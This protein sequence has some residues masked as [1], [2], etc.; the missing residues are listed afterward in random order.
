MPMATIEKQTV[1]KSLLIAYPNLANERE[2]VDA[3][4]RKLDEFTF[5]AAKQAVTEYVEMSGDK[6]FEMTRFYAILYRIQRQQAESLASVERERSAAAERRQ[7]AELKSKLS[8]VEAIIADMSDDDVREF[9][10]PMLQEM[11]GKPRE[12]AEKWTMTQVRTNVRFKLRMSMLH[13][14]AVSV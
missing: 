3:I 10:Q 6:F 1:M 14:G 9:W 4:G 2:R 7:A 8:G 13:G 5:A 11:T 12:W